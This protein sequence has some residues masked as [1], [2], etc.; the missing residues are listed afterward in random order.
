MLLLSIPAR[1]AHN[2]NR[3]IQKKRQKDILFSHHTKIFLLNTDSPE[4]TE[5]FTRSNQ[6]ARDLRVP[7][8]LSDILQVVNKQQ[9]RRHVLDASSVLA[10]LVI[11]LDSQIP[12]RDGVI[13]RSQRNDGVVRRMPLDAADLLLVVVEAGH[14][15]RLAVIALPVSKIPNTPGSVVGSGSEQVGGVPGPGHDVDIV[16]GDLDSDGGFPRLGSNIPDANGAVAGGGCEDGLL[17]GGP[18]DFLHAAGVALEW[19]I[20]GDPAAAVSACGHVDGAVVI[21]SQ[22]LSTG[23]EW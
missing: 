16:V 6:A 13:T 10:L 17:G 7:V 3:Y 21:T 15:L 8:H 23:D 9:L 1:H 5:F 18:L 12:Q 2:R 22:E 11:Q 20:V 14:W 4:H 19:S